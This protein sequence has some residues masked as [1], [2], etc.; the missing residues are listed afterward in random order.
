METSEPEREQL[1]ATF[2]FF[3]P[4]SP[5]GSVKIRKTSIRN[6]Y[7]GMLIRYFDEN[8][9]EFYMSFLRTHIENR[10]I[11]M[12]FLIALLCMSYL[13]SI[14]ILTHAA[15]PIVVFG[16][17]IT[18]KLVWDVV[19]AGATAYTLYQL[20][21]SMIR[22]LEEKIE[23]L[24]KEV[25]KLYDRR[26]RLR[27]DYERQRDKMNHY[28][29]ELATAETALTAAEA[30]TAAAETAKSQAKSKYD[31]TAHYHDQAQTAYM[32]HSCSTCSQYGRDYCPESVRLHNSW[33]SWVSQMKTDKAAYDAAKD[34]LKAKQRAERFAFS[35]VVDARNDKN[36]WESLAN[37][38]LS[39]F[40]TVKRQHAAKVAD[41]E[42]KRIELA[43]KNAELE[44]AMG[45]VDGA[46]R[47]LNDLQAQNPEAWT[48]V[49]DEN[50][51]LRSAVEEVLNYETD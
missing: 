13:C 22:D 2:R 47:G 12:L 39:E 4:T 26:E 5:L 34:T 29:S 42:Q 30:A 8:K 1:T 33:Q 18:A 7:R 36:H 10:S 20:I 41:L 51:D 49:L 21:K 25:P 24:G 35:D 50:P 16:V 11:F 31:S 23:A 3:L 6:S 38:S 46:K 40:R 37:A 9:G 14:T 45:N 44:I 43:L 19:S 15:G 27:G 32:T 48:R 28:K 17:V